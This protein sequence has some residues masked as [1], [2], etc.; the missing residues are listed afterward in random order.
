MPDYE[1]QLA[2]FSKL[3]VDS[4]R[5][6]EPLCN[7]CCTP[8]CTNPIKEIDVAVCG[9]TKKYRLWTVRSQVCQVVACKGYIGER[10]VDDDVDNLSRET[11]E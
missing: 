1:C 7:D 3:L 4:S 10:D 11:E 8:D 5:I 6:E 9:I 2:P